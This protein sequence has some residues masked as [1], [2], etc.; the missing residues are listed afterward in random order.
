[1]I[2]SACRTRSSARGVDE[3][4]PGRR[5]GE[6]FRHSGLAAARDRNGDGMMA[7]GVRAGSTVTAGRQPLRDHCPGPGRSRSG[8]YRLAQ[9]GVGAATS[10]VFCRVAL[11]FEGKFMRAPVS[12]SR[13]LS[14]VPPLASRGPSYIGRLGLSSELL[15]GFSHAVLVGLRVTGR[16]R[17][18]PIGHS[19]A[20]SWPARCSTAT[21]SFSRATGTSTRSP[22]KLEATQT[23]NPPAA[24]GATMR[25]AFPS[26]GDRAAR[27]RSTALLLSHTAPAELDCR[28]IERGTRG[29]RRDR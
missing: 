27:H 3:V 25:S 7:S 20:T 6:R 14:S 18:R 21:A 19:P 11:S 12:H 1:M 10:G 28:V 15:L 2:G 9:R 13:P 5:P 24:S 4:T 22:S 8:Q 29:H 16:G 17:G 23:G 26:L